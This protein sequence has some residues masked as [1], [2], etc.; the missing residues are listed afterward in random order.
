MTDTLLTIVSTLEVIVMTIAVAVMLATISVVKRTI[1]AP[2]MLMLGFLM[3]IAPMALN[4]VLIM[5]VMM[6]KIVMTLTIAI[7]IVIRSF[8]IIVSV[9]NGISAAIS[10][11]AGTIRIVLWIMGT[12]AGQ[13]RKTDEQHFF[14]DRIHFYSP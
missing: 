12:G 14:S 7:I 9:H 1:M 13:Q 5:T 4:T 3:V 8:A 6:W 2:V 10:S 11:V